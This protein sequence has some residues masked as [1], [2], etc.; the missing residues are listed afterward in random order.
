MGVQPPDEAV[1]VPSDIASLWN[2]AVADF[3]DSTHG[4]DLSKWQ[5]KSM[6]EAMA[7][8]RQEANKFDNFRHDKGKVDKVR[9]AFGKNIDLIQKIVNG[10]KMAADAAAVSNAKATSFHLMIE[11]CNARIAAASHIF[12]RNCFS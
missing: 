10:A 7:N 11:R 2:E 5:F 12:N 8:A 1:E 3:K 6:D 4:I 9:T